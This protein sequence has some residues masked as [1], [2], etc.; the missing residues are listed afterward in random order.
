M[1]QGLVYLT[2]ML[3]TVTFAQQATVQTMQS[4][5]YGTYLTDGEGRTLYLFVNE[6]MEDQGPETMTEGV[7]E[8]AAE[9]NEECLQAWPPFNA[10]T[11]EAGEGVDPELLYTTQI[12]D[13]TQVVYNGWPLYYFVRD[14][15][16]GQVNGQEIESFGGEWYLVSPQGTEVEG[17]EG[18]G[19]NEEQS[20]QNQGARADIM[21]A[22]GNM[23]GT[24]TFSMGENGV[25]VGVELSGFSDAS[26]GEHGIHIHQTGECQPDFEA[27]GS[28][29]NPTD[30]NHGFLSP[31][32]PHA[33]DLPNIRVDAEGNASYQ[34]TTNLVTLGDGERSLFDSD[35]SALI[36]HAQPDD[37]LTDPGGG[38]GDRIACGVIMQ[39]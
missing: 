36:I 30:A 23:V 9:C 14:E 38:S 20:Q 8:A 10:E 2:L 13:R 7:R 35:G 17:E 37:Y 29:F 16:P 27:A 34:T 21:D 3:F 18:E 19:Q 32:G 26:E 12:D 11:V 28:H 1:K 5:E 39:Q 15:A 22:Q 24:A 4:D 33:G 31:D 25:E 6:E